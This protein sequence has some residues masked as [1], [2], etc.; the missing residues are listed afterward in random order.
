MNRRLFQSKSFYYGTFIVLMVPALLINLDAHHIFIHTDESLRA[1]IALE[2]LINDEY[3]APTVNGLFYFNKPPLYNWNIALSFK[4]FGEASLFALRFPVVVAIFIYGFVITKFIGKATSNR[5]AWLVAIA[6]VTSGRILFYDSFLGLIDIAFSLVIFT[7]FMLF[8]HLGKAKKYFRLF[9]LTYFLSAIAY[10]MKGLPPIV[11][12][13]FTVMAYAVYLKDWRFLFHKYH[14]LGILFFIVPVGL[15][16]FAYLQVNPQPL[17]DLFL[18]LWEESS[19]RTV[20]DHGIFE[21]IKSVFLFPLENFYHFAP[22]T[23]L[24]VFLF[25]KGAFKSLWG[26]DFYRFLI[27]VFGLNIIVYWTSPGVHPR[28]LFMFLPLLFALLF[29]LESDGS[30]KVRHVVQMLL[31]GIMVLGSIGPWVAWTT[32]VELEIPSTMIKVTLW[33]LGM[34]AVA[35]TFFRYKEHR[36]VLLGIFLLVVRVG[37]NWFVLPNRDEK[38]AR[39]AKAADKVVE[40]T[41]GEPLYILEPNYC[42][43]ATS[44]MI[45]RKR[46]EILE[47]RPDA[48][49]DA[50]YIA[51]ESSDLQDFEELLRFGTRGTD[52]KLVLIK[53]KSRPK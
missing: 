52:L 4:L 33:S 12:Q 16:Y 7:N 50:Y 40:L 37:F 42:H 27:L 45:E 8:Y 51:V 44:F 5:L 1:L 46:G 18:T 14:F 25:K 24:I 53:R 22:W 20:T 39:F 13:G 6:T 17:S 10:L 30:P 48:M 26:H 47:T 49:E 35:L 41:S 9:A 34:G 29:K 15:Y 2:M 32:I 21:S 31:F 3:I 28:Y 43:S 38:G 23:V 11:F 19:K 36:W